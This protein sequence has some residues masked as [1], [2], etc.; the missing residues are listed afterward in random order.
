MSPQLVRLRLLG[1][2]GSAHAGAAAAARAEAAHAATG[3]DRLP[4]SSVW[5]MW[6]RVTRSPGAKFLIGRRSPPIQ[7]VP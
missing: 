3:C 4:R 7:D 1:L 5:E 6:R 2:P